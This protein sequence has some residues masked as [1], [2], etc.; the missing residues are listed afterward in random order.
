MSPALSAFVIVL[1]TL[2]IAGAAWLM[3][4]MR[5]RGHEDAKSTETTGHVWDGDLGEYNNPLPRWWLW[6]F[7][8]TVAFA[9]GY[10]FLYPGLGN[11]AGRLG[12]TSA[13]QHEAQQ[14]E[15]EAQAQKLLSRFDG[16]SVAEL[17]NDPQALAVGRNLFANNCAVCHGSDAHGNPGFPNL[18]DQDWLYGGSPEQIEATIAGGRNGVMI[19]WQAALGND[20]VDNLVAYVLSLSG[21]KAPAGDV[22]AGKQLFDTNCV[23]CHGADAKGNQAIGAP[24]LTDQTWLYG[25]SVEAVRASIANGRQ[26]LMPAQL[27]RLGPLRV[28]LLAAYVLSLGA[29][30]ASGDATH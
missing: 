23:A 13:N 16:K 9:I 30:G 27:D 17:R 4:A 20:G 2:N 1:T 24:N 21:R 6:L 18:T 5:R 7:F 22:A 19:P 8:I 11:Y 15:G 25:G 10:L 28:K 12:W 26:G 3:L 14:R 29:G